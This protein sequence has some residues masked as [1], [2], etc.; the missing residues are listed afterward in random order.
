MKN[1]FALLALLMVGSLHALAQGVRIKGV[2]TAADDGA[3]IIG[4]IV[5]V[6]NNPA[7]GTVTDESGA[8]SLT[9][10][11]SGQYGIVYQYV[12]YEK[13]IAAI[14][15]A[16]T[17]VN[18]TLRPEAG[19]LDEVVITSR[20]KDNNVTSTDVGVLRL[21]PKKI[22][23]VPVLFGEKDIIKTLQLT[24]GVK[25]AGEGNAGFYVRG[26]GADQ[27]LVLVDGAP[28]YNAS[29]LLG[30][31]SVFNSDAVKEAALYKAGTPAEFGGRAS[32]VLDVSM[33]EGDNK[34]FGASG[35]LGTIASRLTL[36]GPLGSD[37]GSFII[38]G[39]RTY[40]DLFLKL[41][42]NPKLKNTSLYF[43]DLNGKATYKLSDKDRLY[44]TGYFGRDVF[45][46]RNSF[47]S[48]W[49][50]AAATARW[51]HVVNS[52][53]FTNTSILFSNYSY[54][55]K[56]NA[57]D[58]DLSVRSFIRDWSLKEDVSYSLN[59]R[60]KVKAGF[61]LTHHYL[62]PTTIDAG[63][64][65]N[66]NDAALE[67]RKAIE[68]GVYVQNDMELNEK[69]SL[70]YGLRY[71]SFTSLGSGTAYTFDKD[72]NKVSSE[73][74]GNGERI[75]S[76]GG[77]EP[78]VSAKYM[79]GKSSSVKASYNRMYQYMHLLSNA[80]TSSPID[81]WI[82]SSNNV[83]P[84]IMDQVSLGYYRNFR[85]NMYE[86]SVE[87]YYKKMQ[88]QIDYRPGAEL[89]FNQEVEGELV[90]GNGIAYG[91]EFLLR[92]QAGRLTG[93][94]S[95]T[96]SRSLRRFDQVN[97]GSLYPAKQDRIHDLAIVAMYDLTSK[98]KLSANWVYYTGNAVTFPGGKYVVDGMPVPYYSGRNA[99]R[100]P[101]YHRL[102][103][104]ATVYTRKTAK[105]ESSWNFSLYNAYGRENAYTI[106]FKESETNPG[107]TEAVQT[108]L[109][110]WIP[111]ITYNFKF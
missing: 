89:V 82:P 46:F 106:D 100:M 54:R 45:N 95:Y 27:N 30:F 85:D 103:I 23:S 51:N 88:N 21:D 64:E 22:E 36:E 34:K 104:G 69:I 1:Q 76:Y 50:N 25:S 44:L 93:W 58:G 90:Y 74:Y 61:S 53:L 31:F 97:G 3:G 108:S 91:A 77:F 5:R 37:N 13:A 111:S 67:G 6:N 4:A 59:D 78:R 80:T 83:K 65:A 19:V 26:G 105:Y 86:L 8:Y 56:F 55:L 12:G 20:A 17:I 52:R 48:N 49:G 38:S 68:G 15:S 11:A 102:D 28:V 62:S 18:I 33:R 79:L 47:G 29:H 32:S 73:Q 57:D 71:S 35:G 7:Y 98:I 84:Q 41:S 16:D 96:L 99:E 87:G 110:R 72:G 60:N 81:Q 43:Y 75:S 94:V 40:A 66:Y 92:K 42:N 9:L 39:R 2:V 10:P 109:F 70:Q 14:S 24:P 107:R 63:A 101:A